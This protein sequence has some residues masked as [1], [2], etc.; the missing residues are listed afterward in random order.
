MS[1]RCDY[2]YLLLPFVPTQ[3]LAPEN[4][5]RKGVGLLIPLFF[6]CCFPSINN[7][8]PNRQ[9]SPVETIISLRISS[10]PGKTIGESCISQLNTGPIK[11]KAIDIIKIQTID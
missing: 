8:V 4:E 5:S 11:I 2:S 6:H 10:Y 7:P 3:R 1:K 9:P